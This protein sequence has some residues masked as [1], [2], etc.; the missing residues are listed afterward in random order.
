[1]SC[2][3]KHIKDNNTR[4]MIMIMLVS[5]TKTMALANRA[6]WMVAIARPFSIVFGLVRTGPFS[7]KSDI[8]T[9]LPDGVW[10]VLINVSSTEQYSNCMNYV[11][12]QA[13]KGTPQKVYRSQIWI[14]CETMVAFLNASH[15]VH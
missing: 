11:C 12:L 13:N 14:H 7:H 2:E 4:T 5:V 9:Q 6:Y 10:K 15:R 8:Q 1:M 3:S